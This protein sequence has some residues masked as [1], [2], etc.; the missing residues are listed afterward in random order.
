VNFMS[1]PDAGFEDARELALFLDLDG[2]LI[3]I[4][5]TPEAAAA[6][7]GVVDLLQKLSTL[8]GGA[9]AI[10]S[11]RAVAE[12]DRLLAPAQFCAA[13]GHGAEIREKQGG[14]VELAEKPLAASLVESVRR[15]ADL[16]PGIVVE[17][18]KSSVAVHYRQ[19]DGWGPEIERLLRAL[20]APSDQALTVR[21]GHKVLE[22]M[23]RL[24]SKGAALRRF[25]AHAPFAGRRPVVIGDDF[26]DLSCFE[27]AEAL[28]GRGLRVAGEFFG[29]SVADFSGPAEVRQFLSEWSNRLET[30]EVQGDA[31]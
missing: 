10:V 22:I 27:A 3:D 12:I 23:P 11:G 6:P 30:G 24:V 16:H 5:A 29:P 1:H 31:R 20:V 8:L 28:G 25:M 15:L 4:A 7:A 2:T 14:E 17:R 9:L 18:K 21:P 19:A 13:G 26:T